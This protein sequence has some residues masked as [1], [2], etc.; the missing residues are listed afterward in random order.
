MRKHIVS[1]VLLVALFFAVAVAKEARAAN[2]PLQG[3]E[4]EYSDKAYLSGLKAFYEGTTGLASGVLGATKD[5][6]IKDWAKD[7]IDDG[8]EEAAKVE[9]LLAKAGG[10]DK[11]AYDAI[12]PMSVS[13]KPGK[14]KDAAF[15]ESMFEHH[16]TALNMS[17][18]AL[19]YSMDPAV[20]K[21]AEE[22]VSDHADRMAE[23]RL[24]QIKQAK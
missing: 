8:K 4:G 1:T 2:M 6:K 21:L 10:M 11:A 16:K 7:I 12:L 5:A 15:V 3:H 20:I 17:V 19:M 9:T 14:D 22:V 23:L 24:W 18:S 13:E